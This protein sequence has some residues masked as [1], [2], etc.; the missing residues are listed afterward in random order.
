MGREEL[1][2][3]AYDDKNDVFVLGS[4][5]FHNELNRFDVGNMT[6]PNEHDDPT[7]S[8]EFLDRMQI[9]TSISKWHAHAV[10]D[11]CRLAVAD[12]RTKGAHIF[13]RNADQAIRQLTS[14]SFER[15]DSIDQ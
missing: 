3:R 12:E 13:F 10:S 7:T 9:R 1:S 2:G 14:F 11:H 5:L 15:H 4:Q 6:A 8:K